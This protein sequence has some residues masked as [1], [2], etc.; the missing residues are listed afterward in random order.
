MA[1]FTRKELRKVF[2][3]AEIEVPKDVLE[4]ICDLH[5]DSLDGMDD[6]IKDLKK[7]LKKAEQ[8][9]DDLQAKIPK[10][11]EETVS[12]STY[13]SLKKDFED[14]KADITAKETQK[15]KDKAVRAYFESK[16]I[17]GDNLE[18]AMRGCTKEVEG[19]ELEDNK[20]KDTSSLDALVGGIF[21]SL[22]I[23]TTT[24][25]VQTNT[26]P[27]SNPTKPEVKSRAAELASQYQKNLYGE[28][29]K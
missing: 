20:I 7:D 4:K 10:D 11:G 24:T 23:G 27:A 14:Y 12:K 16:N 3:D 29:K 13:D 1:E 25:G 22:A 26:P 6:T 5:T 9:R 21:S 15:A 19:L 2:A 8:E 28:V 18:L 17:K